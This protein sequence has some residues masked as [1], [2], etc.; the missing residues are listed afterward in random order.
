M[1][2]PWASAA[3]GGGFGGF[4]GTGST[5]AAGKAGGNG[6]NGIGASPAAMGRK[7]VPA[8]RATAAGCIVAAGTVSLSGDVLADDLAQG[9]LGV[10]GG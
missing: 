5:G 8:G 4:G 6:G 7:V 3:R 2:T 10:F 1:M 9:G